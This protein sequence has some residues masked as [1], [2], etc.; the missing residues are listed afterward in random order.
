MASIS[1]NSTIQSSSSFSSALTTLPNNDYYDVFVSFR[2][3]DTRHSF[4]D[5]LFGA[6]RR[7]SIA[8]F[9]DDTALSRGESIAPELLRAIEGSKIFIVVFSKNYA[10]STWCLQELENILQCVQL[11]EKRVLPVFY[12]VGPSEVRSQRGC[13]AEALAKH[14]EYHD[15]EMV[16]RWRAALTQVGN[17]SGWDLRNK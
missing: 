13:Y 14:E 17:L 12:D 4:T 2:G 8:A 10:S 3:K 16:Q 15:P 1:S 7:K 11:S 6:L 9:R 5:H